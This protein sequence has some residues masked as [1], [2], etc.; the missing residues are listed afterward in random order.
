MKIKYLIICAIAFSLMACENQENEFEDFGSS[1]VYFPFQTPVRTLIQG[2][3][4]L[5][6]NENDN[7]GRF[8]I[9]VIMSGV[10]NNTKDRRVHFEVA[11]GLID[12]NQLDGVN[13]LNVQVLPPAYYTIEQSSPVTI[14]SGSTKG[15]IPV[16]LSDA[17]FDDPLS[18]VAEKD[19]VNYVLPLRIT[20]YE[21]LDSL[22]SGVP[23]DG[24]ISPIK[25]K[26]EDWQ[27]Q[28][29]DYTL[30][31]IKYMNKYQG[32][33]LRR[34]EDQASGSNESVTVFENGNPTETVAEDIDGSTVYRSEFVVGDELLPVATAGRNEV[35]TTIDV[36]RPGSATN[37]K[38]SLLLTFNDNEDITVTNADPASTVAV[39]GSGKFVEDGDEWGGKTRDVIYL[40]FEYRETEVE[41]SEVRFFGTLRS[42]TTATFDLLHKVKDTLVIRDRDVVFEEFT[43]QLN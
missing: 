2:K 33:Y 37:N 42:T 35:T 34:G 39:T 23:V 10:Y 27:T 14:P 29:K 11:P 12:V 24:V 19:S 7:N 28:P 21:E 5:G 26:E 32:I 40:D 31:G 1:S 41:V 22:L 16:Q 20:D 6:L 4:D 18:F 3:Y 15:R 9:G 17:F 38:L 25:I 13:S 36:R 43:V 8:E 30:F